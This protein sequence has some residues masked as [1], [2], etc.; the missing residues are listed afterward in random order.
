MLDKFI[1]AL[2]ILLTVTCVAQEEILVPFRNA[3]KFGLSNLKGKVRLKPNFD[4][5]EPIGHGFFKYS[6]YEMVPDTVNYYDG[7]VVIEE[8]KV[9]KSGVI[10]GREVLILETEHRYFSVVPGAMLVGSW[11]S[12][13]SKNS[14]F[15]SLDGRKLLNENV[16][17]FRMMG[18]DYASGRISES[19]FLTIVAE[20]YNETVNILVF[21]VKNQVMIEPVLD[22][23][24]DFQLDR[25]A[26]FDNNM[27]CTYTDEDYNYYHSRIY[28]DPQLGYYVRAPYSQR[29]RDYEYPA[30]DMGYYGSGDEI[31][32][33]E[34]EYEPAMEAPEMPETNR[35]ERFNSTP[36]PPPPPP[37]IQHDFIQVSQNEVRYGNDT[38][39]AEIDEV[40]QF[41]DRY[42]SRQR[43]PLI[44]QE[45]E[46]MR[47]VFSDTERDATSYDSLRYIKNQY[48][49][50]KSSHNFFYLAGNKNESTGQWYFGLLD[51]KGEILIPLIYQ[52]LTPNLLI[53]YIAENEKRNNDHFGFR[54]PYTYSDDKNQLLTLY[55]EGIFTAKIGDKCGVIDASN[56]TILPFEYDN[57]WENDLSFLK[58]FKVD[59]DFYVYQKGHRYGVFRLNSKKEKTLD[60]G[61]IFPE[62]P[63][64]VYRNYAGIE[65]FDL[66]NL[67]RAKDLFFCLA[68]GNGEVYFR[69]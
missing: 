10:K 34:V 5:V 67:G 50:F 23:V 14:N 6:N 28:Y 62:I 30:D 55:Q 7:R 8:K 13:I 22:H 57:L 12:Y 29:S 9:T 37:K 44:L 68:G 40:F 43:N 36:V 3:D 33:M 39:R 25:N 45:G 32:E 24:K 41:T 48:G 18:P 2:S 54:Q 35:S 31:V 15:Y 4:Y 52:Y 64:Y 19:D 69:P 20:H 26:S 27:V 66:Y 53:N 38:I 21:D 59:D 58:T 61:A 11:E 65:G 56:K 49:I 51:Q 17:K 46:K 42:T 16:E 1:F 60:T 63:V 47:L